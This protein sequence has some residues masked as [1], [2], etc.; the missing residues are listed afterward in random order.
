MHIKFLITWNNTWNTPNSPHKILKL[1]NRFSQYSTENL[2]QQLSKMQLKTFQ[3]A[4]PN[5][6]LIC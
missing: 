3:T 6:S 2:K 1:V 4:Y 5:L